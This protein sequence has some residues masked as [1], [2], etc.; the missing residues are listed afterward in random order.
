MGNDQPGQTMPGVEHGLKHLPAAIQ[1]ASGAK[2]FK[3]N[4]RLVIFLKIFVA[5]RDLR[6]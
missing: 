4:M 2:F 3:C 1:I 6:R 5:L